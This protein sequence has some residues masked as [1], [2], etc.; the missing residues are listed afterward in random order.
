MRPLG[1]DRNLRKSYYCMCIFSS[2]LFPVLTVGPGYPKIVFS[3]PMRVLLTSFRTLFIYLLI[4]CLAMNATVTHPLA[5]LGY[6]RQ[7]K[8]H[9]RLQTRSSEE[10]SWDA[11]AEQFRPVAF[12][13]ILSTLLMSQ[14]KLSI[15]YTS[16]HS[17]P[18]L[19]PREL[20]EKPSKEVGNVQSRRCLIQSHLPESVQGYSWK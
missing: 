20:C 1:E 3:K 13:S 9:E 2:H 19:V 5:R 18:T 12:T 16:Y 4:V 15:W 14:P 11:S 8:S 17:Q 7:S 10:V 6:Q